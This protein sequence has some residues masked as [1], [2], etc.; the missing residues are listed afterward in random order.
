MSSCTGQHTITVNI[1]YTGHWRTSFSCC[2]TGNSS[3]SH[4]VSFRVKCWAISFGSVYSA[5]GTFW[6]R[7]KHS[8]KMMTITKLDKTIWF[9]LFELFQKVFI[10]TS[11]PLTSCT[12][13]LNLAFRLS[14]PAGLHR[15]CMSDIAFMHEHVAFQFSLILSP[16]LLW[17]FNFPGGTLKAFCIIHYGVSKSASVWWFSYFKRVEMEDKLQE[18]MV[19]NNI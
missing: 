16:S 14:R 4:S 7:D 17:S 18:I 9:I 19:D 13:F 3:F 10:T 12:M 8:V 6:N 5:A 1:S 15:N 11:Y 2:V